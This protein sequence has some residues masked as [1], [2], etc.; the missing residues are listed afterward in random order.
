VSAKKLI[1][2]FSCVGRRVQL[3]RHFRRACARLGVEHELFG[4]D[5]S[6][7]QAP[8]AYYCDESIPV[9]AGSEEDFVRVVLDLVAQKGV[10]LL[11]PLADWDLAALASVR[12]QVAALGCLAAFCGP[13]SVQIGRDKLLT[14]EF[15]RGLGLHTPRTVLLAD[16]LVDRRDPLPGFAKPRYGG[17]GKDAFRVDSWSLAESLAGRDR[18][19]VFQEMLDGQ[20]VTVDVFIDAQGKP[21]CVVPRQRLEIRGG[22]VTKARV[23]LEDA[24]LR[25]ASKIAEALPDAFGV[26]NIQ[27]FLRADGRIWW[28]EL[29]PRF[30]GGS[31][32]SIEAGADFPAWLVTLAIGGEPDYSA[33]IRDGLTMLR[34]DDAIYL[35]PADEVRHGADAESLPAPMQTRRIDPAN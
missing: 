10:G 2:A 23:R 29:N 20:E 32:L 19:F 1:A 22:E 21:R 15:F 33:S 14:Y 25:E 17:A 28:T 31:P 18:E 7:A 4:L 26:I 30:G 13:R 27:A 9:P 5:V 16:A 3:V 34:F 6:P 8:A 11:V 12:E 24:I 35:D